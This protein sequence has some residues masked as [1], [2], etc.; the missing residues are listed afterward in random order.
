MREG[1]VSFLPCVTRQ[2]RQWI[3]DTWEADLDPVLETPL[4]SGLW[5]RDSCKYTLDLHIR[6]LPEPI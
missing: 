4:G 1:K 3:I 5:A 2:R 6:D